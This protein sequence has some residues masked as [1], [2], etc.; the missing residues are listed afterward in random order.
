MVFA[1]ESK[2]SRSMGSYGYQARS[3]QSAERAGIIEHSANEGTA[4]LTLSKATGEDVDE[5]A[6]GS[7]GVSVFR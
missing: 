3:Q 1:E 7:L 4:D 5:S 6:R 2:G